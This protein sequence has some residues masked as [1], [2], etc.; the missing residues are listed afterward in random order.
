MTVAEIFAAH[1]ARHGPDSKPALPPEAIRDGRGRDH[2]LGIALVLGGLF[3]APDLDVAKE[4]RRGRT[5][6]LRKAMT[7]S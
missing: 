3:A 1:V 5:E 7:N 6:R 2:N 4:P